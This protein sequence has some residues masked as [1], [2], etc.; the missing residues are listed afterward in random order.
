MEMFFVHSLVCP[1]VKCVEGYIS[2]LNNLETYSGN[3][4][5]GVAFTTK[6]SNQNF[7]VLLYKVQ[8]AILG[9][10]CCDFLAVL[11]QLHSDALSNGRVRLFGFDTDLLWKMKTSE[12]FVFLGSK[13]I[14]K[15]I[16]FLI[17]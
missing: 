9:Y 1:K 13:N 2:E 12:R 8:A 6:T 14:S 16:R 7:I 15:V 11:D 5:D 3:I 4:T 10:E 17:S